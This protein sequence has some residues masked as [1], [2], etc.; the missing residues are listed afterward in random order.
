M[1]PVLNNASA[2]IRAELM[3]PIINP[4][5]TALAGIPCR[6]AVATRFSVVA[7]MCAFLASSQACR[8][9]TSCEIAMTAKG[10]TYAKSNG[11]I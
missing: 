10:V 6:K 9:P 4:I 1:S 7:D 2:R 5:V 8:I 11:N 3:V